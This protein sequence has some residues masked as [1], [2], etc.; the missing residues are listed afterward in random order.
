MSEREAVQFFQSFAL[1]NEMANQSV[2][3]TR[4]TPGRYAGSGSFFRQ[5]R[6]CV[7]QMLRKKG[8]ASMQ[9]LAIEVTSIMC[10]LVLGISSVFAGSV[11]ITNCTHSKAW[12]GAYNSNDEVRYIAASD[13][14]LGPGDHQT[15]TCATSSCKIKS[16]GHSCFP[17]SSLY[18][19]TF[20]GAIILFNGALQAGSTC[21]P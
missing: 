6:S 20:K 4:S 10:A 8:G 2:S 15:L 19:G 7:R 12:V 5:L 21:P 13:A 18:P 3:R 17:T 1:A 14:C 11:T 16:T 9:R